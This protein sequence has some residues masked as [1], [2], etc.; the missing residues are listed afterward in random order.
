MPNRCGV[1]ASAKQAGGAPS[2][3]SEVIETQAVLTSASATTPVTLTST[4]V[5]GDIVVVSYSY[6]FTG[7]SSAP[8]VTGGTFN[9]IFT[10]KRL[11]N[12]RQS[13]Y[14]VTGLTGAGK[15]ITIP[16]A[17]GIT[18][19]AIVAVVRGLTS[20]VVAGTESS[21]Y[22]SVSTRSS[23]AIP[24]GLT[25]SSN[26]VALLIGMREATAGATSFTGLAPAAGWST[27]V[28]SPTNAN[29]ELFL[30]W[31]DDIV[32]SGPLTG[33]ANILPSPGYVGL[34]AVVLGS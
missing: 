28:Q 12:P 6:F 4:L 13:A 7:V 17:Q 2:A 21:A 22:G 14:W 8:T 20:P 23:E 10:A 5:A 25:V 24:G 27:V 34:S 31:N 29:G 26:K 30:A 16:S 1:F 9:S 3:P 33:T 19:A 32:A 15:V 18:G 11:N